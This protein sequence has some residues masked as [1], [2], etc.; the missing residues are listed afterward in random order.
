M[1]LSLNVPKA[2]FLV[3]NLRDYPAWRVVRSGVIESTRKKRLDGLIA[4]PIPAGASTV[5]IYYGHMT[6]GIAGD[7]VTLVAFS[8]LL[9]LW[10]L[11]RPANDPAGVSV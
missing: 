9:W 3:L 8:I 7:A 10:R 4:L 1:H 6:D 5:D 11:R 2:G